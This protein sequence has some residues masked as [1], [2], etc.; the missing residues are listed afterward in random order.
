MF[1]F[2]HSTSAA[3]P[4]PLFKA[5]CHFWLIHSFL[6]LGSSVLHIVR[7]NTIHRHQEAVKPVVLLIMPVDYMICFSENIGFLSLQTFYMWFMCTRRLVCVWVFSLYIKYSLSSCL[8][9]HVFLWSKIRPWLSSPLC[10]KAESCSETIRRLGSR[11]ARDC[12]S[13]S[14]TQITQDQRRG[15]TASSHANLKG[16][17]SRGWTGR[18]YSNSVRPSEIN[19]ILM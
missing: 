5:L 12:V 19:V 10:W 8:R 3:S 17:N 13:S 14:G 1:I 15:L 11:D 9:V 16:L 7:C 4:S 6:S 18:R 2:F